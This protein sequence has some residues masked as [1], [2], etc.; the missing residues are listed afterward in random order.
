MGYLANSTKSITRLCFRTSKYWTCKD[1]LVFCVVQWR[2]PFIFILQM[3]HQYIGTDGWK[4]VH[5]LCLI[6]MHFSHWYM[7]W[8]LW[9]EHEEVQFCTACPCVHLLHETLES[10]VRQGETVTCWP[11]LLPPPALCHSGC[12]GRVVFSFVLVSHCLNLAKS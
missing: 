12:W 11:R 8:A 1:Y 9:W 4:N 10:W 2:E 5:F 7:S 3:W 6:G